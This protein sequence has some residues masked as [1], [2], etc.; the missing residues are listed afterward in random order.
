VQPITVLLIL[1]EGA[2]RASQP[3]AKGARLAGCAPA[4]QVMVTTSLGNSFF[5]AAG[6]PI[7]LRAEVYDDCGAPLADST[8]TA[9]FSNN[10]P[11]KTLVNLKNGQ[12]VATWTPR[13]AADSVTVSIQS[14][15]PKFAAKT[16]TLGGSLAAD[17]DP[18]PVLA[19]GGVL[20]A[21]SRRNSSLMA[22]G[23]RMALSGSYFP[24]RPEDVQVMIN[25]SAAKVLTSASGEVQIVAPA[26][27]AGSSKAA[28][29]VRARGISTAAEVVTV[30]PVDPGLLQPEQ[31]L[32]VG[33]GGT[34]TVT[35]TGL[36]MAGSD[37]R[38]AVTL[39]AQLDD[40]DVPVQS[41]AVEPDGSGS[42]TLRITVAAAAGRRQLTIK[43][44]GV[45]SNA[46][47]VTV[48]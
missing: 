8:L 1:K 34:L 26:D 14:K 20:N 12:Y 24:A 40:A 47:P 48:Q 36:G 23:A 28:V 2:T 43:A 4:E 25:G 17:A 22:P 42:Y 6:W 35:A 38:P 41:A 21:F 31:E 18:P 19:A 3:L 7:T 13:G 11:A 27:F 29:V 32:S 37:G 10:D 30:V 39:S 46:V 44:N 45:A 9:S 16:A 5:G 33:A 15:S